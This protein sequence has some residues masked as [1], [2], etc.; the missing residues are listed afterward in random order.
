MRPKSGQPLG[1]RIYFGRPKIGQQ[2]KTAVLEALGRSRLTNGGMVIQFEETFQAAV[3]GG[4]A[5][6]VSS[7][8]AALHLA[9]LALFEP[10]DEV[11]V[12]ALTHVST[13]HA[14]EA[15]GARPVFVDVAADGNLDPNRV[16]EALTPKTKGMMVVHYL[17]QVADME[18]LRQIKWDNDLKIVEDC[19]LALGAH[20]PGGNHVG[21]LGDGGCFSFYPV[22]HITTCEGGMFITRNPELAEK[23]KLRRAFGQAERMGDVTALGLNYRMTEIQAAIGV[24]QLKRL[25][26]ILAKRRANYALVADGFRDFEQI[27]GGSHYGITIMLPDHIDRADLFHKMRQKNVEASVY[28]PRPVPHLS[29]YKHRYG[30]GS[31]PVAERIAYRSI[32]LPVGPHL[33]KRHILYMIKTVRDLLG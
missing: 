22:K 27:G 33:S 13:A 23:I 6:A 11:I 15:M 20:D 1:A 18:A 28:Y 25:P 17:G 30:E 32:C 31:W 14:V 24:E 7:C 16:K 21:F 9:C 5:V 12:P 4:N 8:T 2:E 19:A 29:Y 26:R 10:G 3:G